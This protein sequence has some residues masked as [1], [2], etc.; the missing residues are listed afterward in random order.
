MTK[1][2]VG[3]RVLTTEAQYYQD[4]SASA[5]QQFRHSM[6]YDMAF[7]NQ[8]KALAKGLKQLTRESSVNRPQ[9]KKTS[10]EGMVNVTSESSVPKVK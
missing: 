5:T 7:I 9:M 6:T 8:E 4:V 3:F 10:N 2:C 1:A